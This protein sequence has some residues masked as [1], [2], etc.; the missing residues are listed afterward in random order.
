MRKR[1]KDNCVKVL[2]KICL[3]EYEMMMYEYEN[4]WEHN[5]K[6]K[7]YFVLTNIALMMMIDEH[8]CF[9]ILWW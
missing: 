5:D 4:K 6:T 3:D 2:G 7:I 8:E 9:M 1:Q